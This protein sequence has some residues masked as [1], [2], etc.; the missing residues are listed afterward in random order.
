VLVAVQEELLL[1]VWSEMER[2]VK[3]L[4]ATVRPRI[5]AKLQAIRDAQPKLEG[6]E[7][8][9]KVGKRSRKETT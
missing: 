3:T 5:Q 2:I 4:P 1:E 7:A 8:N 9:A 6:S